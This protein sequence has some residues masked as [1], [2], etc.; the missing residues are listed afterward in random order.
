MGDGL[1]VDPDLNVCVDPTDCPSNY[2]WIDHTNGFCVDICPEGEYG[3]PSTMEC[4][5]L[6][7]CPGGYYGDDYLNEC[8]LPSGCTTNSPYADSLSGSRMCVHLDDCPA[9]SYGDLVE[10]ECVYNGNCH[11]SIPYTDEN[12]RKCVVFPQTPIL[13]T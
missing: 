2:P 5:P 12:T 4:G 3:D 9:N 8:V 10:K 7:D 13:G 6:N 1:V 11:A